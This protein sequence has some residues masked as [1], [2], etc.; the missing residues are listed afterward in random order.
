M[1]S[2]AVTP[3]AAALGAELHGIDLREPLAREAVREIEAALLEYQVL[4]FRGQ[5]IGPEQQK[6][7]AR[8]FGEISV[9]PFAPKHGT[10][11]EYIVLD[12]VAPKGQ[13]ADQWHSDN[14]FVARPPMGSILKA[15]RLPTLGGDTCF[16]SSFAAYEALSAPLRAL[17]D[18]LRAVHDITRPLEKA[19][20]HGQSTEDLAELQQRFPPVEHP[21]VRTHP[22]T[23]RRGL[24][25]NRNSTTRL[26]GVSERENEMLLPFLCD[27]VRSP[28]FQ[29]RFRWDTQSV[30]FWDNRAV[31]HFA[32]ADYDE[33]R[34]MHRV[35]LEGDEPR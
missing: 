25:V 14:T 13:G 1:P 2:I 30:V 18:E 27:H 23:G 24:F 17:C 19:I 8:N 12:Q 20:E 9:P 26:L 32:V 28:D 11:P 16:A 31:Q 35:T 7:F 4:F 3:V 33:R 10:D 34:I 5:D 22:V 29:C 6:A 15:V 21:V